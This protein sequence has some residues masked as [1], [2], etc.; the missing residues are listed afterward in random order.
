M[1]R[2]KRV[3]QGVGKNLETYT[4]KFFR[5]NKEVYSIPFDDISYP[6]NAVQIMFDLLR[7]HKKESK[8]SETLKGNTDS[9][10]SNK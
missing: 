2:S 7:I 1:K 4:I 9:S 5:E 6:E 8:L 10:T 3:H